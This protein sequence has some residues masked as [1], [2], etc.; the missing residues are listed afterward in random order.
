MAQ[1]SKNNRRLIP[2]AGAYTEVGEAARLVPLGDN[3]CY[4]RDPRAPK[5]YH[6]KVNSEQFN[7]LLDEFIGA[8]GKEKI[9]RELDH[10]NRTNPQHGWH[11]AAKRL[12]SEA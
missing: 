8:V 2:S 10:L 6:V 5:T 7:T 3:H 11:V 1:T 12:R 9:L 4:M